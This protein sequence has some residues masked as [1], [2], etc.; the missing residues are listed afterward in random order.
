MKAII[1]GSAQYFSWKL[2]HANG[3]SLKASDIFNTEMAAIEQ[4]AGWLIDLHLHEVIPLLNAS[5]IQI[6]VR[7]PHS[8]PEQP[9]QPEQQTT[10]EEKCNALRTATLLAGLDIP[11]E[12]LKYMTGIIQLY[13]KKGDDMNLKEVKKIFKESF[14][15][16]G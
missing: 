3:F 12:V 4:A 11:E 14:D 10:P 7:V 1:E 13:M 9:E 15:A 2:Q 16:A 8:Q 5:G 6:D